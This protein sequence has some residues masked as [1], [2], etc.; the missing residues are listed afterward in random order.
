MDEGLY[1][2]D[3]GRSE[4]ENSEPVKELKHGNKLRNEATQKK[5]MGEKFRTGRAVNTAVSVETG[6]KKRIMKQAAK[7]HNAEVIVSTQLDHQVDKANE[8]D[9]AGIDAVKAESRMAEEGLHRIKKSR[10]GRDKPEDVPDADTS[11]VYAAKLHGEKLSA[12]EKGKGYSEK[13]H[14]KKQA[15]EIKEAQQIK[16]AGN[17]NKRSRELQHSRMKKE[18]EDYAAKKSAKESANAAGGIT[19]KLTDEAEDLVGRI[20]EAVKE[21]VE[22][23]P[24]LILI[25]IAILLLVLVATGTLSSCGMIGAGGKDVVITT[26]YTA[27]DEDIRAVEGDY[28]TLEDGIQDEIDNVESNYPGYDEYQYELAEIGHDPFELAA[29]LTVLYEDYTE[30][31]VQEMLKTILSLQYELTYET[32]VEIRTRTETRGRWVKKVDGTGAVYYEYE[33]YEVEVEYEYYILKVTLTNGGIDAAVEA[34]GL[35]E[36]Q[37]LRYRILL[38]TK[39]NKED[40]FD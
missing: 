38:E 6:D 25:L 2:I 27:E 21:F 10:Y 13:L 17:S 22:E 8:D 24:V 15:R 28:K 14:D 23:H 29:L 37:L 1:T 18:I 34:L 9:N 20:A 12:D 36:D 7:K 31:E 32:I 40:V 35:T 26:S 30:S 19:K 4:E 33:T 5:A 3:K 11:D 16:A 39:G